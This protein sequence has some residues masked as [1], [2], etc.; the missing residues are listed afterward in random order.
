MKHV[1]YVPPVWAKELRV[2]KTRLPL[3]HTPTPIRPW[4]PP[5]L[6]EGIE[7]WIKRDDQTGMLVS[8][9]KVRKLEFLLADAKQQGCDIVLTCGGIQSNHCRSTV[10]AAR[11]VGLD[12]CLFL[13]MRNPNEPIGNQGNLFINR[14]LGA[15][16]IPV[17]YEQYARRMEVMNE[18]AEQLK[19]QGRKPYIIPEGGSDGVGTW[20]YIECVREIQEQLETLSI[21]IDDVVLAC[22]SGGTAAG[23]GLAT[24]LSHA[25]WKVHVFS[26]CDDAAYFYDVVDRIL[27][28]LTA[29]Q[30]ARAL[31]DIADGYKGEGYAVSTESEL[32]VLKQVAE[33]TG[34]ILDPVYNGK[35]FYGMQKELQNNPS[36]FKGKR[37]LFLHTGGLFGLFDKTHQLQSIF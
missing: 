33:E 37:I 6:P 11:Q 24:A 13:R 27:G 8:G 7:C 9:N 19:Q 2:P 18:H 30:H 36:C 28:E 26:V 25:S 23:V 15:H 4:N 34:V 31:I 16:M 32:R 29:E 5:G 17:S 1:P 21:E 3:A 12:A 22:G 14:M 10:A 35:A 20:G